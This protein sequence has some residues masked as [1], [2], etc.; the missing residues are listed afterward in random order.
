MQ[1]VFSASSATSS[2]SAATSHFYTF[3]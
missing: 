2:S 1:S 3:L